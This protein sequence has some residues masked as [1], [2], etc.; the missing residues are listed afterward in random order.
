MDEAPKPKTLH[1]ILDAAFPQ[2]AYR[3][4]T[5]VLDVTALAAALD[6]THEAVY[7]WLRSN[8]GNGRLLPHRAKELVELSQGTL[9]LEVLMP[10]VFAGK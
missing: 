4:V 10:F 8:D 5:G 9:T 7:K 1:E 6:L 3:T 2:P